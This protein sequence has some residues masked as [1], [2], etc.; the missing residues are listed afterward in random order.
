LVVNTDLHAP[1]ALPIEK[2]AM[3]ST[4]ETEKRKISASSKHRTP[5]HLSSGLVPIL[6]DSSLASYEHS[7]G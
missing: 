3:V 7:K 2:Y 1:D 5:N 4:Q 6:T